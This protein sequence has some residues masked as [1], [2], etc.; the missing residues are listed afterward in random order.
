MKVLVTGARGMLGSA[1][2][3]EG[4]A[5]VE[6]EYIGLTREVIDLRNIEEVKKT[7][8]DIAPD[9]VLHC[10]AKVGGIQANIAQPVT[11][12]SDNV[13][14]DQ[15][16]L[17]GSKAANVES[18]VYFGSSCMYPKDYRQPLLESDIL[19][20]PLEPTNEGYALAKIVGSELANAI[21]KETGYQYKTVIM[22]NLYGP[23]DNY[24]GISSHLI[25]STILKAHH[26][27]QNRETSIEV[28]GDGEARREFTYVGDVANWVA[29]EFPHLE[30]WP[31]KLNI[32]AGEDH[33]VNEYYRFALEAVGHNVE[34]VHDLTKPVGM[35]QKLMDS[36]L[37]ANV[38]NWKPSTNI[39][40]GYKMAYADYLSKGEHL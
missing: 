23:G 4:Q 15:A 14:I 6:H 40:N 34:L 33:S 22:S 17:L 27:K 21:S 36:S 13:L 32:G 7:I 12:L 35:A 16:V 10:A 26:S 38:A 24:S 25:A 9:V 5:Q 18:L 1:I 29:T 2:M 30:M 37:A 8:R 28:W 19:A 11:F 39:N 31:S 20:G 3:R